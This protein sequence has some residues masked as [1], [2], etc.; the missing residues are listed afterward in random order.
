MD[1]IHA[2]QFPELGFTHVAGT[3]VGVGDFHRQLDEWRFV[4]LTSEKPAL[5]GGSY[6]S[7][8]QL[9]ADIPAFAYTFGCDGATRPMA[10]QAWKDRV[11]VAWLDHDHDQ[12]ERLRELIDA[13]LL[14]DQ[15]ARRG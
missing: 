5:V 12:L 13:D 7:R 14:L 6:P 1:T 2:T 10:L 9:I 11:W 3:Q 4:D 8:E 15:D